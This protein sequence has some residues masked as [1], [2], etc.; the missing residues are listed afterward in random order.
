M[1]TLIGC[2]LKSNIDPPAPPPA[3]YPTGSPRY[4]PP[5]DCRYRSK[6]PFHDHRQRP[7][8][9]ILHTTGSIC[10]S[11][12]TKSNRRMPHQLVAATALLHLANPPPPPPADS[13]WNP[14][15]RQQTQP[16]LTNS[17][18]FTAT[19]R[20]NPNTATGVAPPRRVEALASTFQRR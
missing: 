17:P 3:K 6:R 18:E 9:N 13:G 14:A 8:I 4:V 16:Q 19:P 1:T 10:R 12:T 20:S 7:R 5:P 15:D 11:H 2:T